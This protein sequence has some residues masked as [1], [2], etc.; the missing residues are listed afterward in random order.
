MDQVRH[1]N[2]RVQ[3]YTNL[4]KATQLVTNGQNGIWALTSESNLV[5]YDGNH[6]NG[7][8]V[9]SKVPAST[10]LFTDREGGVWVWVPSSSKAAALSTTLQSGLWHVDDNGEANCVVG[11]LPGQSLVASDSSHCG[12]LILVPNGNGSSTS[13]LRHVNSSGVHQREQILSVNFR[14]VR[15]LADDGAD[16]ALV[17]YK[18][19][20]AGWTLAKATFGGST[21]SD[22][23]TCPKN[24]KISTTAGRGVVWVLKKT[25]KK[26]FWRLQCLRG[27]RSLEQLAEKY[28]AGSLLGGA[29]E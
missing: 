6:C 11:D 25:G 5:L 20:D 24:A 9:H 10:R 27:S 17:H 29:L 12:I 21:I 15:C 16:G 18:K 19:A 13:M 7:L 1:I 23:C 26:R 3:M 22:T 14:D 28:P 2:L 8:Q 4:P